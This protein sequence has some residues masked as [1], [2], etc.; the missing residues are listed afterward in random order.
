MAKTRDVLK[1]VEVQRAERGR[2]CHGN[3]R[4]H[5][6][7]ASEH[8]LAIHDARGGRKNYCRVCAAMILAAATTT[9][10]VFK[11]ELR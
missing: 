7:Q 6:I 5:Q 1:H 10:E 8:C 9:L 11:S 3:R 4:T 2:V